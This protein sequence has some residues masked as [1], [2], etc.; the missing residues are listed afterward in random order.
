M[1][2]CDWLQRNVGS[3][4]TL[5]NRSLCWPMDCDLYPLTSDPCFLR[6]RQCRAAGGCQQNNFQTWIQQP[7]GSHHLFHLPEGIFCPGRQP[8]VRHH[9][10][11]HVWWRYI[12]WNT[13]YNPHH[14]YETLRNHTV[15]RKKPGVQVRRPACSLMLI[16]RI[17][18]T[19][20]LNS[21]SDFS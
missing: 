12:I 13:F 11:H 20:R 16:R 6:A 10:R 18:P 7:R 21:D 2:V 8:A 9:H 5:Y 14:Q 4:F 15:V 1:L 19:S 3:G 17:Y